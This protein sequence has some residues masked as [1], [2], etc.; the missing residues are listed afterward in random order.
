MK[1]TIENKNNQ[2]ISVL[3]DQVKKPKGLAFVAHGLGGF[4]EQAHIVT[5]AKAFSNQGFN[6]VRWDTR[7]TI[8]ES[9]GKL[10]NATLTGYYQDFETVI[11][12]SSQQPWYE[13]PFIAAGHSLG[14]ACVVLFAKKYPQKIK[15]LAPLSLFTSGEDFE[16]H[17]FTKEEFLAWKKAGVREWVSSSQPGLLKK[18]KFNFMTDAY[19]YNLLD[20]LEKIT[21]PVLLMVGGEDKVTPIPLQKK[22]YNLIPAKKKELHVIKGSEHTFYEKKHLQQVEELIESWLKKLNK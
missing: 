17:R 9:E 8:G 18:L 16:K 13:E 5:I 7:Q 15:A 4:K 22:F 2:K 11:N 6:V 10:I 12:W 20:D 14:S 1:H 21:M 3:V 19:Q